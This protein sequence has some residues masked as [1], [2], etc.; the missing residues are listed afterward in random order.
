MC[1]CVCVFVCVC[2]MEAL[3]HVLVLN[4]AGC[5]SLIWSDEEDEDNRQAGFDWGRCVLADKEENAVMLCV[6]MCVC[7]WEGGH[8]GWGLHEWADGAP[9]KE[10]SK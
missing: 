1:V 5:A 7:D 4:R 6:S 3:S 2:G 9:L 8:T 10:G